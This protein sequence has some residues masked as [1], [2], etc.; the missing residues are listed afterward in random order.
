MS[1]Q[2]AHAHLAHNTLQVRAD[3]V[4]ADRVDRSEF[5]QLNAD[6]KRRC[7]ACFRMSQAKQ[8]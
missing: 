3:G 6:R 1:S 8:R 7:E 2:A 4:I 5:F